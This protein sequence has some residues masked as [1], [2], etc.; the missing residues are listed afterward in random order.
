[1]LRG[2]VLPALEDAVTEHREAIDPLLDGPTARVLDLVAADLAAEA[3]QLAHHRRRFL[4]SRCRL[5]RFG[6]EHPD[7]RRQVRSATPP[8]AATGPRGCRPTTRTG[9]SSTP[10]CRRP[11]RAARLRP[12]DAQATTPAS[13]PSN[14]HAP[15]SSGYSGPNQRACQTWTCSWSSTTLVGGRGPDAPLTTLPIVVRKPRRNVNPLRRRGG[16]AAR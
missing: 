3:R 12:R 4:L 14:V 5:S 15:Y 11:S 16:C 6:S 10:T 1:M 7:A 9:W 13:A 2:P 8:A